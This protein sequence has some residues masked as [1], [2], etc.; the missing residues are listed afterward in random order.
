MGILAVTLAARYRGMAYLKTGIIN[1][2]DKK[3]AEALMQA[4]QRLLLIP[5]SYFPLEFT[6]PYYFSTSGH[7]LST[8]PG[9]HVILNQNSPLY[10]G[11]ATSL[12][13]LDVDNVEKFISLFRCDFRYLSEANRAETGPLD[14]STP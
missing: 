5:S 12:L 6:A 8:E 13:K 3:I 11:Q 4:I 2:N 10:V 9:W 14:T 1:L 7:D